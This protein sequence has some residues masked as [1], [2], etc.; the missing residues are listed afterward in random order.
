MD[1]NGFTIWLAG[2][3]DGHRA[4]TARLL[5]NELAGQGLAVEL[6]DAQQIQQDMGVV[7]AQAGDRES[8]LSEWLTLCA[9][10][11]NK[12]GIWAV[13]TGSAI[14]PGQGWEVRDGLQTMLQVR[15]T[16]PES[17]SGQGSQMILDPNQ[18]GPSAHCEA[19]MNK[20]RELGRIGEQEAYSEEERQLVEARLKDLGYM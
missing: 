16:G 19:I 20:L 5:C 18:A 4:E 10:L 13:V 2:E 7:S 8:N 9:L 3:P 11:L 6:L 12:H 14:K 1:Q 17:D 15:L